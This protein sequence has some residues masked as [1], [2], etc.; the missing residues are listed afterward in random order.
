MNK[1][2]TKL[3]CQRKE[4]PT[5]KVKEEGPQLIMVQGDEIPELIRVIV[6]DSFL[7][8]GRGTT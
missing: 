7:E 6:Q 4:N 1:L 5:K 2:S 8:C 3:R